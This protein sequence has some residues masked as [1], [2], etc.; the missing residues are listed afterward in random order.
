[1]SRKLHILDSGAYTWFAQRR[2][3]W[4]GGKRDWSSYR[5]QEFWDYVDAYAAF[6]KEWKHALDH[7]ITVDAVGN[8][9][10]SWDVQ[11]YLEEKH[12]LNPIPVV[13]F[14]TDIKELS[15]YLEAG[16]K[17]IG[18]GGRI[19]RLP[20]FPWADKIFNEICNQQNRLP[21]VKTHAFAVT[22]HGHMT[23]YPW[24]SCDST[25]SKKMAYYGQV[26]IPPKR[27]GDFCWQTP[28]MVVFI[29][30]VSPYTNRKNGKGRHFLHYTK[31]EQDAMR[32]WLDKIGVPFGERNEKGEIVELGVS[33]CKQERVNATIKYF[34]WL[35]S[36][37]PKWPWPFQV[38]EYPTLEG[39]LK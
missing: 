1:M 20:Y 19:G 39:F 31:H 33:T 2:K 16:Y 12:G 6:V 5:T 25:T 14:G 32:E 26:L 28:N 17:Y 21:L 38:V 8:P 37:I 34:L 27:N 30:S 24:Y 13:H 9:K 18:I 7:Y 36:K 3:V 22:T 4:K 29:D 23:R 11:K 15:R 10:I 35:Q